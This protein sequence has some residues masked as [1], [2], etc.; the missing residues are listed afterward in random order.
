MSDKLAYTIATVFGAGYLPYVPGT[1]GSLAGLVC[2]VVFRNNLYMCIAAFIVTFILGV[3][4][5][6]TVS[7]ESGIKDPS[8]VVIDEFACIFLAFAG[9]PFKLKY[10]IIGFFVYRLLDTLKPPPAKRLEKLHG[11]WGIMLDDLMVAVYTALIL[12]FFSSRSIF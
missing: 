2:C 6:D 4:A 1:W 7:K 3:Y 8:F 10:Y 12:R 5:A 9:V 11:G